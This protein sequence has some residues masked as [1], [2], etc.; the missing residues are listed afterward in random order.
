MNNNKL[1]YF[2][3]EL[4]FIVNKK[5]NLNIVYPSIQ[6]DQLEQIID[7]IPR[8]DIL[9]NYIKLMFTITSNKICE[10]E[11]KK[12]ELTECITKQKKDIEFKTTKLNDLKKKN[13]ACNRNDAFNDYSSNTSKSKIHYLGIAFVFNLIIFIVPML[14]IYEVISKQIGIYLWGIFMLIIILWLVYLYYSND[15]RDTL[16]NCKL[17]FKE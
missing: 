8:I 7:P 11:T 1:E 17:D 12:L 4:K 9:S 10:L 13:I 2:I 3:N 15:S 6:F 16:N 14:S 5:T